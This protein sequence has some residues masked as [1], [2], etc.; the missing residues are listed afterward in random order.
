[1]HIPA[2]EFKAWMGLNWAALT[3]LFNATRPPGRYFNG[4]GLS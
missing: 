3:V 4:P 2:T 1:M